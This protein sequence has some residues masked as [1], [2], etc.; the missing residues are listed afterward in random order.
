VRAYLD[1]TVAKDAAK[2]KDATAKLLANAGEVAV[3]LSA[4]NPTLPKDA[5]E[6]LFQTHGG[7][8]ITQIQQLLDKDYAAEAKTWSDMSQHMYVIA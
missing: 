4:A 1:A 7:H 6:G 3:F 2:Q 5:V 8:H